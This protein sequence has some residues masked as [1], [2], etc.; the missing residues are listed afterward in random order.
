MIKIKCP[1]CHT[2]HKLSQLEFWALWSFH[3]EGPAENPVQEPVY[4]N[5]G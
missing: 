1:K 2:I 4:L 5:Y 3:T